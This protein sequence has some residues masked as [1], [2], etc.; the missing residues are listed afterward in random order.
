MLLKKI[1]EGIESVNGTKISILN[2]ESKK[3]FLCDYFV[4]CNGNSNN[5]VFAIYQSIK[6]HVI[7]NFNKKPFHIEGLKNKE[8][9][10]VDYI[11]IIVHVFQEEKRLYYDIDRIWK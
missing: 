1:I 6:K 11:S 2:L 4:I 7:K 5:Q 3:N 9:I 8:W 10:L